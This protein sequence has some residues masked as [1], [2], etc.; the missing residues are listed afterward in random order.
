[1]ASVEEVVQQ[2]VKLVGSGSADEITELFAADA[3]LEDPVGSEPKHGHDGIREFYQVIEN[4]EK[5]TELLTL[6]VAGDNAAF[7]FR[8]VTVMGDKKVELAPID[9]MTFDA[10]A[11]ISSMRAFWSQADLHVS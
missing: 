9:V 11:K 7:C 8:L 6:R 5:T 10:D 1:M 4:L 2:Y 3:V